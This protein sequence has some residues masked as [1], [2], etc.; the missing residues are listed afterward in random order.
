MSSSPKTTY[1]TN[2]YYSQSPYGATNNGP[3]GTSTGQYSLLPTHHHSQLVNPNGSSSLSP[4]SLSMAYAQPSVIQQQQQPSSSSPSYGTSSA[5]LNG[6]HTLSPTRYQNGQINEKTNPTIANGQVS[7]M[8]V[9]NVTN[10]AAALAAASAYRRNYSAC[11]KP[12]Y[13]YFF[14]FTFT[15]SI[16]KENSQLICLLIVISH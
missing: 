12:P 16:F 15:S 8:P 4:T 13:R 7:T 14:F 1:A 10:S 3:S 9:N 11:A 6:L 2:P 5:S